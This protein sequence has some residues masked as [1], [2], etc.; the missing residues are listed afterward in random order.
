[1]KRA[2]KAKLAHETRTTPKKVWRRSYAVAEVEDVVP[3]PDDELMAIVKLDEGGSKGL[4]DAFFARKVGEGKWEPRE[5]ACPAVYDN[6]SRRRAIK[7]FE[8]YEEG[9]R[10]PAIF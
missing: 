6:E 4:V 10:P 5:L 3:W 9:R 2:K 8:Y 1:M 7:M